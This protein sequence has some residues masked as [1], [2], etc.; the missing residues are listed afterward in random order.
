MTRFE[1]GIDRPMDRWTDIR[2]DNNNSS[3]FNDFANKTIVLLFIDVV[4][5]P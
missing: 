4:Y 3:F 1:E 2:L 5:A